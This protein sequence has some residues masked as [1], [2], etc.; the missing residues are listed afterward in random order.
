MFHL[1]AIIKNQLWKSN[2]KYIRYVETKGFSRI[3]T[4]F[5]LKLIDK[6]FSMFESDTRFGNVIIELK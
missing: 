2:N 6:A 1:I 3:D 4:V 5:P